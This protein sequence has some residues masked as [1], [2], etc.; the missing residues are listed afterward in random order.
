MGAWQWGTTPEKLRVAVDAAERLFIERGYSNVKIQDIAEAAGLG[1]GSLYHHFKSSPRAAIFQ[2]VL[3]RYL[4]SLVRQIDPK[5]MV[6]S[7]L[8]ATWRARDLVN[9]LVGDDTPPGFSPRLQSI[10]FTGQ[11]FDASPSGRLQLA[12]LREGAVLAV[13][14][15]K[16]E[17]VER[18]I[19]VVAAAIK[20]VGQLGQQFY[21]DPA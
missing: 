6:G 14:Y 3:D 16:S 12:L 13:D 10:R 11:F 18:L 7:T 1:T 8:R 21:A 5:D 15:E 4:E 2:V 19:P 17:D 20:L 9:A